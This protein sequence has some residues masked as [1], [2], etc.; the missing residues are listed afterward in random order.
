MAFLFKAKAKN[1]QDLV[2]AAKDCLGQLESKPSDKLAE[3][4]SKHLQAMKTVLYGDGETDPHPELVAQLAQEVYSCDFL[5]PL[6]NNMARL[7]FEAKKDAAQIFGNLLRR[8]IGTRSP[9]VEYV[10]TKD[11]LLFTLLKDYEN[12]EIA[13]PAGQMLREALRY[14]AL[15]KTVLHSEQFYKFFDYVELS[16]FDIA[17]DAFATFKELLTRHKILC[18]EFLE[19]NYDRIFEQYTKLLLSENY[20]TRRQSLKLLGELLLDRANFSVMTRY[21]S[22]PENL[23]M[24]MNMLKDKSKNIQFESFHVFKVFVA[25]PN[26]TKPILDILLKNRDKLVDFLSKFHTERQDDEQFNDEKVYLIKQIKE[27]T[28]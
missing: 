24:M 7:E 13:L 25:N 17:S 14:E 22:N 15:A 12:P 23:K 5:I 16:T 8:Q 10:C 20:V 9:T 1:P 19:K 18:A 2:R 4:M 3:E 27:L 21:I 26:K 28:A 11:H 6:V